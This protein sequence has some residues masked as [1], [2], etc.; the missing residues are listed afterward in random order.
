MNGNPTFAIHLVPICTWFSSTLS[1]IDLFAHTSSN[2]FQLHWL[3]QAKIW[4]S[5]NN[6]TLIPRTCKCHLFGKEKVFAN[7]FQWRI[8]RW[9]DYPELSGWTLHTITGIPMR[10][11]REGSYKD[12]R[13]GA[14]TRGRDKR[15]TATSEDAATRNRKRQ[16][17]DSPLEP[18]EGAASW[19]HLDFWLL[20]SRVVKESI[21]V[22]LSLQ[23]CINLLQLQLENNTVTFCILLFFIF[24]LAFSII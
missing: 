6:Y 2:R 20:A 4:P 7:K 13:G 21:P 11:D 19:W 5:K 9:G 8:C 1:F 18:P 3:W 17:P 22:V 10:Q 12:R 24:S 15:W 16:G 14:V 23:V